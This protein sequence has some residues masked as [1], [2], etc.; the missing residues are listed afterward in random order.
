[1][2]MRKNISGLF[3]LIFPIFFLSIAILFSCERDEN[4]III[5]SPDTDEYEVH[6]IDVGQGDAILVITPDKTLLVDG[7]IRTSGV[8]QYLLDLGIEEIDYVIGTHPHADHI[9]G[10]IAVFNRLKVGEVIDPGVTHTTVTFNDYLTAIDAN[11]ITFTVGRRG[12]ERQLSENAYFEILHP[13]NPGSHL[14]NASVVARVTLGE[15][16]VLLTGDAERE[17]EQQMLQYPDKLISHI[18]KVG[19]HGSRTSSTTPFLEAVQPEVSIIMCGQN[20]P[21]GH[22][23]SQAMQNLNAIGTEI[24]RTDTQGHIFIT[25]DGKN[26]TITTQK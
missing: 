24:Y 1:M 10:L 3:R 19:H 13:V 26:Y 8:D 21:Y 16:R 15:I 2:K 22:P 18:L 4:I 25:S 6:F 17:A 23:H 5:P 9:G 14:N 7:G 20:N 11:N 12:M